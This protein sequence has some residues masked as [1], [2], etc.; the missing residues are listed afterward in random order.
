VDAQY[1]A[2]LKF[3]ARQF[4]VAV[5][6]AVLLLAGGRAGAGE[7]PYGIDTRVENTTLLIDSLPGAEGEGTPPPQQL[8]DLPALLSA[9]L[10]EDQSGAGIFPYRPSTELWSDGALKSRFLA[11]PGLAQITY[12]AD[13]GWTFPNG[14]TLIKNFSLPQ[15]FRDPEGTA[16]RIETRLLVRLNGSW[17]AYTYEWNEAETDAALVSNAGATRN[18]NLIDQDGQALDYEWY[19]PSTSD[20]FRC[21][22]TSANRV[23][24]LNTAQMNHDFLYPSGV[25]DN[26]IRTFEHLGLFDA[27]LPGAIDELP[28]SPDAKNDPGLTNEDRAMA[29]F[30]ANCAYCH[31][32][33]GPAPTSIDF[34]WGAKLDARELIGVAPSLSD[35]GLPEPK[36]VDPGAPDNSVVYLRM[37]LRGAHQMPPLGTALVDTDAAAFVRAW[38]LDLGDAV[39]ITADQDGDHVLSLSELLR[40]IQFYNSLALYC[41]TGTEDGFAPGPG[42]DLSCAPHSADYSPQDWVISLSELLRM[43]QIYNSLGYHYCPTEN[44]EDGFCPGAN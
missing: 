7:E 18:F 17:S 43:I 4:T 32:P 2:Q 14:T 6:L 8:S 26:Q 10:G 42:E 44:T 15:D 39:T 28:A 19:Y 12:T 5:V 33:G 40:V 21:H 34:R 11:L 38:I 37:A 29:Y 20:C 23:L 24:G 41:A 1:Q 13:K 36:R 31:R 3:R 30:Q 22:N 35:L 25:T 16:K 27:P 9:A